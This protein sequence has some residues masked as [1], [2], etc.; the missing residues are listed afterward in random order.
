V[1]LLDTEPRAGGSHASVELVVLSAELEEMPLEVPALLAAEEILALDPEVATF[2]EAGAS[3]GV[4]EV[5]ALL[6]L[7]EDWIVVD[8]RAG[9]SHIEVEEEEDDAWVDTEELWEDPAATCEALED[10]IDEEI[11]LDPT[12]TV[13]GVESAAVL[14]LSVVA[15]RDGGSHIEDVARLEVEVE[16]VPGLG[17]LLLAATLLDEEREDCCD[18]EVS[19]EDVCEDEDCCDEETTVEVEEETCDDGEAEL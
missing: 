6:M 15:P 9:G 11:E 5:G 2:E 8:P 12:L 19:E 4:E 16:V 10:R 17:G 1:E 7:A 3:D 18:E 14:E 13:L